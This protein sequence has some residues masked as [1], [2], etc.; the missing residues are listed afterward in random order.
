LSG[1]LSLR[2]ANVEIGGVSL[3]AGPHCQTAQ[4]FNLVLTGL[5]PAYNVNL[6]QGALAGT[7]TI[8]PFTGCASG[9]YNLDPLFTAS[10]S[11]PGNYVKISQAPICAPETGGG[12][13]PVNP[14]SGRSATATQRLGRGSLS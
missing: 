2:L 1:R 9:G 13:P 7:V 5:P 10:V 14:G 11:G 8:P 12:C 6:I 4:P 3:N